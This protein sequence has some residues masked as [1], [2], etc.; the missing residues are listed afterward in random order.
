M[1]QTT[2]Q[3]YVEHMIGKSFTVEDSFVQLEYVLT[4][5]TKVRMK[6]E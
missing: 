2:F 1:Q 6:L 4:K 5:S 3:A